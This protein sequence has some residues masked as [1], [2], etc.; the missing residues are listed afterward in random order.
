MMKNVLLYASA[1]VLAAILCFCK[2]TTTTTNEA[3]TA[4][5]AWPDRT[6]SLFGFKGCERAG[7]RAI[8]AT[9][10]EFTYQHTMVRVSDKK[11]DAGQN[12]EIFPLDSVAKKMNVLDEGAL[13]FQ[14][15]VRNHMLIDV[16]TGPDQRELI[17]YNL[18]RPAKM[19]QTAY[20][21]DI[22]IASNGN[23]R[24]LLPVEES[25]VSKMPECPEK[26]EWLKQGLRVGYGQVCLFSLVNRSLTRKSEF[27]C[28][29]KQ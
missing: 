14:G 19:Y 3:T 29:A 27:Q 13:F 1:C 18:G 16:G 5:E 26:E 10:R 12:I 20:V 7:F 2:N 4:A 25:E 23:L 28:V 6:D 8:S 9:E 17:I 11:D 24:F 21:G 15:I 22:E